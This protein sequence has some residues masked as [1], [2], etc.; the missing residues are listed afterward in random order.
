MKTLK[1]I[2]NR[3]PFAAI[4]LVLMA[5]CPS[6]AE[7]TA[8][9]LPPPNPTGVVAAMLVRYFQTVALDVNV[10]SGG[11][12]TG[13]KFTTELRTA[14]EADGRFTF[15]PNLV[16]T[17]RDGL[18]APYIAYRI[19]V[20]DSK[21]VQVP[22]NNTGAGNI[23]AAINANF[24]TITNA[25][26]NGFVYYDSIIPTIRTGDLIVTIT[27]SSSQVAQNIMSSLNAGI[28]PLVFTTSG[29]SLTL[30]AG[31]GA[32]NIGTIKYENRVITVIIPAAGIT[33]NGAMGVG[34]A[35]ITALDGK[36]TNN[37]DP[38]WNII[39]PETLDVKIEG[40]NVVVSI[41]VTMKSTI[42][43]NWPYNDTAVTSFIGTYWTDNLVPESRIE[44]TTASQ[45]EL[46]GRYWKKRIGI[47]GMAEVDMSGVRTYEV[48]ND[49]SSPAVEPAVFVLMDAVKRTGIEL[50]LY[51]ADTNTGKHQRLVV[52]RDGI[53]QP[54]EF[55]L[56][57]Y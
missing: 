18:V 2:L 1:R 21:D 53:L 46:I 32:V 7:T 27:L 56:V 5:G 39:L 55:Y 36:F 23:A 17:A 57:R 50:Y 38:G 42:N 30:N 15:T 9:P 35:L 40:D 52:Y 45:V 37:V 10:A 31:G 33:E 16:Y 24:G 12:V 25:R 22:F 47:Q 26:D 8:P 29:Q 48:A 41:E 4:L 34:N 14:L 49:L 28:V 6:P 51:K 3:L 20:K 43:D 19:S 44:F 11:A 54:R 13:A